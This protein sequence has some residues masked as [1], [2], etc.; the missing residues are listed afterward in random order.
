VLST[1]HHEFQGLA[2]LEGAAYGCVPLAPNR[3]AY[4]E[5]IPTPCLYNNASSED[6][7]LSIC[8]ILH[9]WQTQGLPPPKDV[10]HYDWRQLIPKYEQLFIQTSKTTH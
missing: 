8:Q 5:W 7:A 1:A 9:N 6:E 2:V 3:L 10:C 4:P